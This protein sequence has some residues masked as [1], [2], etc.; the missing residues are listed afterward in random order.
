MLNVSLLYH[1]TRLRVPSSIRSIKQFAQLPAVAEIC[2]FKVWQ[3]IP[4]CTKSNSFL[5]D[6]TT[7][8]MLDVALLYNMKQSR[9][10]SS[11]RSIKQFAQLPAVAEISL[12]KVWLPKSPRQTSS[13]SFV[14][15]KGWDSIAP[16]GIAAEASDS[17]R[18]E[19]QIRAE[20]TATA[21][22][23]LA[24]ALLTASRPPQINQVATPDNQNLP[25]LARFDRR[26]RR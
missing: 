8:K 3:S 16:G 12:F 5:N 1:M 17:R 21:R 6:P 15:F 7:P 26:G 11:I 20:V 9:V 4:G 18:L 14:F 13:V 10:P 2:L 19:G 22:C 24:V 23:G 25:L